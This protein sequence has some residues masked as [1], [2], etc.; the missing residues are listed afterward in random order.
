[1][2]VDFPMVPYPHVRHSRERCVYQHVEKENK[3]DLGRTLR[4]HVRRS[5]LRRVCLVE[6]V[7]WQCVWFSS[8]MRYIEK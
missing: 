1:M 8:G 6:T 3:T 4:A 2:Y 5:R 7:I